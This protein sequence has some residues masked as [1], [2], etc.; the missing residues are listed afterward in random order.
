MVPTILLDIGTVQQVADCLYDENGNR[1]PCSPMRLMDDAA[2]LWDAVQPG[3][4]LPRHELTDCP[5]DV[6]KWIVQ[7]IW[8]LMNPYVS[9]L[10]ESRPRNWPE[11]QQDV[12]WWLNHQ[13]KVVYRRRLHHQIKQVTQTP[14]QALFNL[15]MAMTR[16]HFSNVRTEAR[17][18][19]SRLPIYGADAMY[20]RCLV[21]F[22]LQGQLP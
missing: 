1:N 14:R 21:Y 6:R 20:R 5:M 11:I 10:S 4:V 19:V 16:V 2:V 18:A 22:Y 15:L 8:F 17:F 3:L 9:Q 7:D 12:V 13:Q